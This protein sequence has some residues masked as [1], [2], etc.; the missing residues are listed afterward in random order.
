MKRKIISSIFFSFS[1]FF[2]VYMGSLQKGFITLIAIP[3]LVFSGLFYLKR[4]K[5]IIYVLSCLLMI[6]GTLVGFIM[7]WLF[8]TFDLVTYATKNIIYP[9][10]PPNWIL[11]LYLLFLPLLNLSFSFCNKSLWIAFAFGLFGGALSYYAGEQIGAVTVFSLSSYIII[12]IFWG[13]YLTI[14]VLLNRKL[15]KKVYSLL[16]EENLSKK[17]TVLF[18][19]NCPI[20]SK[21]MKKLEKRKKTG[22]I[23]FYSMTN[24]STLQKD[25][26][27]I[28]YDE[29]MKSIHAIKENGSC[30]QGIDAFV[31]LY[32]RTNLPFLASFLQAPFFYTFFRCCYF[33]WTKI[34]RFL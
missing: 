31:Q 3:I 20:C 11:G 8:L 14:M 23:E 27:H 25:W 2:L 13:I 17:I 12:A 5:S 10:F 24:K 34:R 4:E 30:I 9:Y 7:E 28:D 29:A 1:W 22:K 21:E 26:P 19:V 15:Q 18:D 33:F 32:A 6:Y 16:S